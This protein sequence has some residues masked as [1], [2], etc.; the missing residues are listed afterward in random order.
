MIAFFWLQRQEDI[1]ARL[2]WSH[3]RPADAPDKVRIF[4]HKTG[5]LVDSRSMMRTAWRF[6]RSSWTGSTQR[7]GTAL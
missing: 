4:H 5:E 3:Y 2:T 6:G 7:R 1:L